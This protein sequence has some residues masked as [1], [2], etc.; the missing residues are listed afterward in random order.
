MAQVTNWQSGWSDHKKRPETGIFSLEKWPKGLISSYFAFESGRRFDGKLSISKPQASS[1]RFETLGTGAVRSTTWPA[2]TLWSMTATRATAAG[3]ALGRPRRRPRRLRPTAFLARDAEPQRRSA[4]GGAP[5]CCAEEPAAL[6][7][8]VATVAPTVEVEELKVSEP[9]RQESQQVAN[10]W[11][12]MENHQHLEA[13]C[14][15]H[16]LVGG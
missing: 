9:A 6:P 4:M 16:S 5:S 13:G 8:E 3:A 14:G 11:S 12:R 2:Q 1:A 15:S 10:K 7:V